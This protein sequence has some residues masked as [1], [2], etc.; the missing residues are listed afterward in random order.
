MFVVTQRWT[1][2][3]PSIKYCYVSCNVSGIKTHPLKQK[4]ST[5][6]NILQKG[7]RSLL[8]HVYRYSS[9]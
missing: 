2:T 3:K 5:P 7:A 4:L 9:Q 8:Y 1:T 6:N